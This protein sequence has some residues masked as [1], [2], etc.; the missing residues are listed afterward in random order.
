MCY[1]REKKGKEVKRRKKCSKI[2]TVALF[3]ERR[4]TQFVGKTR[5]SAGEALV[6][7]KKKNEKREGRK[8]RIKTTLW[9]GKSKVKRKNGQG[10][11]KGAM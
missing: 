2:F 10:V 7:V 6:V 1:G 9:S 11:E 4:C 8:M 5:F 3:M